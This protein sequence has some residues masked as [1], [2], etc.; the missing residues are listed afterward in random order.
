M[1]ESRFFK[2]LY[3]FRMRHEFYTNGVT[4][5]F[6]LIPIG[7][8]MNWL[9]VHQ[10]ILKNQPDG[11]D[12][13][14]RVKDSDSIT[15]LIEVESK[16]PLTFGVS[17]V[18]NQVLNVTEM[19]EKSDN[20]DLYICSTTCASE[21][22]SWTTIATRSRQFTEQY[23]YNTDKISFQIED[24]DGNVI[25]LESQVGAQDPDDVNLFHFSFSVNLRTDVQ[26]GR[27]FLKTYRGGILEEQF[28][29]F[30]ID[31]FLDPTLIGI[32]ELELNDEIDFTGALPYVGILQYTA[33]ESVW[34]YH[35]QLSR[36]FSGGTF[37][38]I[39]TT[40]P[41]ADPAPFSEESELDDYE[42]GETV[43]FKSRAGLKRTETPRTNYKLMIEDSTLD[44]SLDKLPN[45]GM[46]NLNA[47]IYLKI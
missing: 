30:L 20:S 17:V 38:I 35:I 33:L 26:A 42:K 1:S 41:E 6:R 24:I 28:E 32:V 36:D 22:L 46:N 29:V 39:D 43:V 4:S 9:L 7:R 15:P 27:Y 47:I 23:S 11:F 14:Y 25:Y 10:M 3:Q 2:A 31:R 16:Y 12:L 8:T 45:P 13:I 21:S 18:N 37:S 5:D 40:D 34:Y 44:F 19:P